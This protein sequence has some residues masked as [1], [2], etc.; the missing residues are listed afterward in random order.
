MGE[1]FKSVSGGIARFAFAWLGPSL[2]AVTLFWAFLFRHVDTLPFFEQISTT[3]QSGP[4][5]SA[6]LFVAIALLL[7]ILFA[8][9]ST[10]IYRILEGLTLPRGLKRR[11]HQKQ[12]RTWRT[13]HHLQLRQDKGFPVT[14]QLAAEKILSYPLLVEDLRPT[15][16]GNALAAM[17]S[18]GSTRYGLDSQRL[19][20][21]LLGVAPE[22]TRR[23]T[24]EG[25]APVDF[26]VSS[27]AHA[28]LLAGSALG[29]L[30]GTGDL[31][32]GLLLA[33]CLVA[34]PVA[35]RGAVANITDWALTVK[36]LVNLGRFD[37]AKKLGLQ[38]P[39]TIAEERHM[40]ECYIGALEYGD[41]RQFDALYD[42]YRQNY[43][44]PDN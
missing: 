36:A 14:D 22:A 23:D 11:L 2:I 21:E 31:L 34:I 25:R 43:S 5:T 1:F 17:E 40:W 32:A 19:W 26:Y 30:L 4:L 41:F 3:A 29:V 15:R 9:A 7:S 24:E 33:G 20:Y 13:L 27:I 8:Y 12:V 39:P 18:W 37:L 6:V 10:P 38:M 44:A 16:L 35:Y 42:E 28:V